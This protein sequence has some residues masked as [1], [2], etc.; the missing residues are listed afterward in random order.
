[1]EG[2]E[3]RTL[4]KYRILHQIGRGTTGT[5]Y[6][7]DD[8]V[9]ER[10]VAIKVANPASLGQGRSGQRR[11]KLLLNEARAARMLDHPNIVALY[12]AGVEDDLSHIVMEY[13][14][15]G[16]TLQDYCR[17]ER[18][19]PLQEGLRLAI[20]VASALD[21]AHRKSVV[22]RDIKP[23]NILL[24]EAGEAK[25]SDFGIA[26]ITSE[27]VE[28]TQVL[29]YLG[30]P[31]YMSP[32]QLSGG[33]SI[34]HHTDI[35]SLGAVLYELF[36]GTQA[37]GAGSIAEITYRI[38]R[39][40]QLPLRQLRPNLPHALEKIIDRAL[41]KHPAGRYNAA[42]DLA[43][44]LNLV[45]DQIEAEAEHVSERAK[46]FNATRPLSFFSEFSDAELFE[47]IDIG[48][49]VHWEPDADIILGDSGSDALYVLVAGEVVAHRGGL[50]LDLLARG[51]CFGELGWSAETPNRCGFVAK[52]A[53]TSL[54]IPLAQLGQTS[55]TCQ[56]ELHR[57]CLK[58]TNERL[59]RAM[60]FVAKTLARASLRKNWYDLWER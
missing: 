17:P 32:E 35:F 19:L 28:E 5:I 58:S 59:A 29:G 24:T 12:D 15:G 9:G 54:Q 53:A 45:L 51:S 6:L 14:P 39:E 48:N 4:G 10:K 34:T 27:D 36:T 7:A 40:P 50:E 30:S 55:G 49:W 2:L 3:N 47:L 52:N 42:M 44:D 33:N 25:I 38:N 18:L 13:V 8:P 1:M 16:K 31:L 20:S 23:R 26:L 21:Y 60:D 37:F 22:H 43:G 46:R 56:L 41:K 57:A 11:R